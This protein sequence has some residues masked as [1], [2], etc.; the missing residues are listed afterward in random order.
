MLSRPSHGQVSSTIGASP[1]GAPS[2][3]PSVARAT[4]SS[5]TTSCAPTSI[6]SSSRRRCRRVEP[7]RERAERIVA[8]RG[9]GAKTARYLAAKGFSQ[10]TVHTAVARAGDDALG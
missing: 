5:G 2:S 8:S 4:R 6:P 7:E 10:D 1:S 9:Q 3:S